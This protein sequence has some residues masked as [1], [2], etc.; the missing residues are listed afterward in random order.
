MGTPFSI[1][2]VSFQ[3]FNNGK[4][5]CI[6]VSGTTPAKSSTV[7]WSHGSHLGTATVVWVELTQGRQEVWVRKN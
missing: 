4:S 1:P 3:E 6:V 2:K 5:V 7:K